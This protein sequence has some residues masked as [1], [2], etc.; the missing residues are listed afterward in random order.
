MHKRGAGIALII[1]G[2]IVAV[3]LFAFGEVDDAPGMCAI[4]LSAGYIMAMNG[5][6]ML[7]V[8]A[9][10]KLAQILLLS[11]AAFIAVLTTMILLD[12]EFGDT[13]GFS[14]VGYGISAVLL[15][16]GVLVI[17]ARRKK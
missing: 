14:A 8:I 5:L 15:I 2:V 6:V 10:D 11:F 1:L 16:A 9:K 4:G 12:G 13:P 7:G 3:A 17:R